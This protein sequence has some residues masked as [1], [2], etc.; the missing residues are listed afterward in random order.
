MNHRHRSRAIRIVPSARSGARA[1]SVAVLAVLLVA[2]VGVECGPGAIRVVSRPPDPVLL[3]EHG[4]VD[5]N[6]FAAL[7]AE[8]EAQRG[9]RFIQQPA[10]ELLAPDD[11]RL[12]ALRARALALEPCPR[13][14]AKP[15]AES[16]SDASETGCFADPNL[17]FALCLAPPDLDAARQVLRRLLD[18]Q[19]YPRLARAAPLLRGDPGV[20]IRS[21][22]AASA[23]GA[24][25][26][27][28]VHAGDTDAAD[29][30]DLSP[31]EVERRALPGGGCVDMASAFLDRQR[32]VE[33]PFRTPPLSTLM[34]V[35]PKAY[36]ASERPLLLIGKPIDVAGC[37]IESDE[38]IG[39]ARIL[40]ELLA[41]GGSIPGASLAGWRGDRALR[42]AC[43]GD[44]TPW[45]YVV[46]L[47]DEARARDFATNVPRLL[48]GLLP[49]GSATQ[50]SGR[51]VVIAHRIDAARARSW[52]A[53]LEALQLVRFEGLE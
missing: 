13:V 47:A 37:S 44:E 22:L 8:V 35:R 25:R 49:G 15:P 52:A 41:K 11:A 23:A 32:D 24:I 33:A 48:P 53:S 34:M 1:G 9:L 16:A 17:E 10:L 12:P 42:L 50:R 21:L 39:V 4:D 28:R 27:S 26:S 19:N 43:G 40:V 51:R 36:R 31:I 14:E 29:I 45:I 7:V 46:E 6:G 18:A 38:S 3:D 5:A 2:T 30:L 20:A